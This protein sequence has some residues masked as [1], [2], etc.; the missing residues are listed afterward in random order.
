[1]TKFSMYTMQMSASA[2]CADAA[3]ACAR[4]MADSYVIFI[5]DAIFVA[6]IIIVRSLGNC[7][8]G[9]LVILAVL[10]ILLVCGKAN[11]SEARWF[12]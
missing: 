6:S 3:S 9:I 10:G 7:V 1:M 5:L 11:P 4:T 8:L 12:A 2:V